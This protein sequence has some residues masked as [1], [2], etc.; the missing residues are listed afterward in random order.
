MH[1]FVRA[2]N[3]HL[4]VDEIYQGL[5]YG[6][7]ERSAASLGEDVFVVNSFSK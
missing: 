5:T 3:G 7:D 2:K 1:E 4:I 6:V